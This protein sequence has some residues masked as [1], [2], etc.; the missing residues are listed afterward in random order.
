[1]NDASHLKVGIVGA[2]RMGSGVAQVCAEAGMQ[3]VLVDV[4]RKSIAL[5]QKALKGD[6][7]KKVAS[8]ELSSEDVSSILERIQMGTDM[9]L[10]KGCPLCLEAVLENQG[11]KSH[12]HSRM[13][14]ACGPSAVIAT[15][16][17]GLSV[18]EM[19][20]KDSAPERFMG[21]VFGFPPQTAKEAKIIAAPQTSRMAIETAKSIITATGKT[22]VSCPDKHIPFRISTKNSILFLSAGTIIGIMAHWALPFFGFPAALEKTLSLGFTGFGFLA[23]VALFIVISKCLKRLRR[24]T[25]AMTALAADDLSVEIPDTDKN[26]DYGEMAR[27]VQVFKTLTQNLD[28]LEAEE[29]EKAQKAALDK[30][31][32]M[33]HM[34]TEFESGVGK[35]V[36]TVALSAAQLQSNAKNLSDMAEDTSRQTTSIASATEEAS[37]SVQTVASAAE[38]LSV[39]I[40]EINRQIQDS[41]RVAANAV[42]EVKRTDKTVSTLAE[43][44]AQIGDV[45]KLIQAIA[46]QTNLLALNATIEAARAGEAGKGFA[47]VASEVK[48]LANQTA[49]ATEE[50][51]S[52]IVTV[53]TVSNESVTAIRN[54]GGVIEQINEITGLIA[55]ALHQQESATHEISKNVQ[56]ASAGTN[57]VSGSIASVTQVMIESRAGSHKVLEAADELSHQSDTLR[58]SIKAFVKTIMA[59]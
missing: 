25:I 24:I 55:N 16:T 37:A 15:N 4:K 54:I 51:A 47:V 1:M 2:G 44:A 29:E 49:K 19:A 52:K 31:K 8:G 56:Q 3:V 41:S 10:L 42:E 39:S 34:A 46:E 59:S 7:E 48:N 21:L 17:I 9:S 13:R 33:E 45:V 20:E 53:Q 32:V 26:D 27:I 14:K 36:E 50:I 11:I 22:P 18:A 30:K 38:E 43:A 28:K 23:A 12:I 57:E 40:S 5:A 35:I 6:L 58:R